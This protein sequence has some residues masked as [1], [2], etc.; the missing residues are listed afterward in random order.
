M[1]AN[2]KHLLT[3][4]KLAIWYQY[5]H[6]EI[7]RNI[8]WHILSTFQN[9]FKFEILP[10]WMINIFYSQ[11]TVFIYDLHEY[12][13]WNTDRSQEPVF[14]KASNFRVIHVWSSY[15][16]LQHRAHGNVN[17]FMV[18]HVCRSIS[19]CTCVGSLNVS[20]VKCHGRPLLC[21]E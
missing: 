4:Y 10:K 5:H 6:H 16:T 18:K 3:S 1:A 2:D 20:F 9:V 12:K 11:F 17:S 7:M 21:M 15:K 13:L 19:W 14:D 8:P